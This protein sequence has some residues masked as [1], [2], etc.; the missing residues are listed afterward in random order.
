[1]DVCRVWRMSDVD[2]WRDLLALATAYAQRVVLRSCYALLM[3]FDQ[4]EQG[5]QLEKFFPNG[6]PQKPVL[7][8]AAV[9][10]LIVIISA[11][12]GR[13][14]QQEQDDDQ[15]HDEPDHY[16]CCQDLRRQDH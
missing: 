1:V 15:H 7:D 3:V 4:M 5:R 13:G 10:V 16:R 9:I 12:S 8:T 14:R 11:A 2:S 6:K